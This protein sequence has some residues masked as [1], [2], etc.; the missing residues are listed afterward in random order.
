MVLLHNTKATYLHLKTASAR[1]ARDV[2]NFQVGNLAN[3]VVFTFLAKHGE[4]ERWL[5]LLDFCVFLQQF[6][7]D[8][9]PFSLNS[10]LLCFIVLR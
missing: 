9:I 3:Q 8:P 1:S 2:Q 7:L 10:K 6:I 4:E 5:N